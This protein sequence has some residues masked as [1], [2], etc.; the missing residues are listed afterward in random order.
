MKLRLILLILSLMAFVFA[1]A[2]GYFYYTSFKEKAF[3][4]A[5][6]ATIIRLERIN[7]DL[8]HLLSEYNK[9]VRI[10][11][12]MLEL[13]ELLRS[14]AS[15]SETMN[16]ANRI[17]DHFKNTLQADV[18]YLMDNRGKTIASSNRN[19]PDSFVG[20]NFSFRPYFQRAIRGQ[21]ASY[22][23]LGTTSGKR[24]VYFSY[25]VYSYGSEYPDGIVVIKGSIEMIE[26]EVGFTADEIVMVTDPH[27][28][29]F[30]SNNPEWLYRAAWQISQENIGE[31]AASRQFGNGPWEWIGLRDAEGKYVLDSNGRKYLH[32]QVEMDDYP[33]W[34]IN[35]L[36]DMQQIS[37]KAF[38][39]L[40]VF[41][42]PIVLALF[43][44][45]CLSVAAL[46]R[47]ASLE[48]IQRKA[49]EEALRESDARYRSLYHNTPAMLHSINRKGEIVSISNYW[50]Q[51][52]GYGEQ[53]VI[54]RMLTDFFTEESK[55]YAEQKVFPEFFK[56]GYCTDV[57][58]QIIKKDGEIIDILLSAIGERDEN[59]EIF[60]TLAIL[61]DVT[62]RN[63]AIEALRIAKEELS[64]YSR[65]L[66]KQ[67]SI[68]TRE[69]TNILKYTPDVVYV[70]DRDGR[71]TLVNSPF[72]ELFGVSS[73]EV[74]GKTDY[75]IVAKEVAD[76]FRKNDLQVLEK[77]KSMQVEEQVKHNSEIHTYLSVK[78]PVY[79]EAGNVNGVCGISTDI[80][81]VKKAQ[82]QLRRLSGR[83]MASQ[84]KERTA[85]ARE[86]HDELGQV[87][88]AL[89][90][91]A[92]WM[93]ERL[94]D[95]DA[96]IAERASTMC[97]LIDK[98]IK[99]VRS[100]AIR[101]RP[102]VLDDLGLVDALEW[103][104]GDFENRS[105]ITCVFEH[106]NVPEL[107]ETVSTAAYRICQ[108]TLTNV[109]RYAEAGRVSVVLIA[110]K[111][112][113]SL[114]VR[115]DGKG[116]N[117][118]DLA[119]FEGV[120]IAGMRERAALAG[121][122]LEV[123]SEKGRGCHVLFKVRISKDKEVSG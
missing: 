8:S 33:G 115:D 45:M 114:S 123:M 108:E 38:K 5:E 93:Q 27:G 85:I 69:I 20:Q 117:A 46:Y 44:V 4:E 118:S 11:A 80:T 54:G 81:A 47:Q 53:E 78:F 97:D 51:T 15:D 49:A 12:G 74:R 90:M 21:S 75:E 29:I 18:C 122:N 106:R 112:E 41:V 120:G 88:T 10:L 42:R 63:R 57:P 56:R 2:G 105:G 28:I 76:E 6:S 111:G 7:K 13:K 9:P 73:E 68:R 3:R 86:L 36:L 16:G 31:I 43:V 119:G 104:T 26:R 67:V 91:D 70:K 34:K 1:S 61:I 110:E 59:G 40:V 39:P 84:E 96:R 107:N 113:L 35:H 100:I 32:H 14:P 65:D 66:E 37:Q 30:I 95:S 87:L 64:T 24:G 58:Y 99:D 98:T 48:I 77:G 62:E 72:E 50:S 71:Y 116:F 22:L 83:I 82:D 17:L 109:A 103:L 55:R 102:G 94:K 89:R 92:V 25:P 19:D 60:R 79:D 23:A 101:L 52:L 121:G